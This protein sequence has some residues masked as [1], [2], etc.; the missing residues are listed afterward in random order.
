MPSASKALP[1]GRT[2]PW[3][4]YTVPRAHVAFSGVGKGLMCKEAASCG[5]MASRSS[6][7]IAA[8]QGSQGGAI[9][10]SGGTYNSSRRALWPQLTVSH[11]RFLGFSAHSG[12]VFCADR[13]N[14]NIINTEFA[15]PDG[16]HVSR[17]R[18]DE[19]RYHATSLRPRRSNRDFAA[20]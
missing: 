13:G 7:V 8:A 20:I 16:C 6:S 4:A 9:Y 17:D 19:T 5:C 12:G 14:I 3:E 1:G 11:C 10:L 15:M 2:R 18:R